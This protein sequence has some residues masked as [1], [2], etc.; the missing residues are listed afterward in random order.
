MITTRRMSLEH[1]A[2]LCLGSV[3]GLISSMPIGPINLTFATMMTR[4]QEREGSVLAATVALLDGGC[5][6][7]ALSMMASSRLPLTSSPPL[8]VEIVACALVIGY[9]VSLL[10]P[11][12]APPPPPTI[13]RR[14]RRAVAA[15][16]LGAAL[17]VL[18]P[19]LAAFWLSTA[20]TLRATSPTIALLTHRICFAI[21]A[22][23]G[24]GMWF[25]ALRELLR[26]HPFPLPIAHR[27]AQGMGIVLIGLGAYLMV[28]RL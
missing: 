9:G 7:A 28:K 21:G 13:A 25:A 15:A 12:S 23:M 22:G 2:W 19:A 26:R 17:Y 16:V 1:V 18:N 14:M 27:V 20:L 11:R 24:V 4:G 3:L 5:A 6:F 8:P 10:I